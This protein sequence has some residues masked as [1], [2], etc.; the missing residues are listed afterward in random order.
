MGPP[1]GPPK[2]PPG[3]YG[4]KK[5][6][7]GVASTRDPGTGIGGGHQD[8]TRFEGRIRS[9]V[10]EAGSTDTPADYRDVVNRYFKA[11]SQRGANVE[12]AKE[13]P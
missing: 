6:G 5:A 12:S 3:P 10:A 8:W 1:G 13:N 4:G 7:A 2:G 11:L 9:N